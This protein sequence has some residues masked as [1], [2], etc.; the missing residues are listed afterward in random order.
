V[1]PLKIKI[2]SQKIAAGNFALMD[3]IPALKG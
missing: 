2:P 1:T 3:L